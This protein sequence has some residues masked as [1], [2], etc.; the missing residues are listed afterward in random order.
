MKYYLAII[1]CLL[2]GKHLN[3][4]YWHNIDTLPRD[5]SIDFVIAYPEDAD[6]DSLSNFYRYSFNGKG[7]NTKK[8]FFKS[9]SEPMYK[10]VYFYNEDDKL[11]V[12]ERYG[13]TT[14]YGPMDSCVFDTISVVVQHTFEYNSTQIEKEI[15]KWDNG[16]EEIKYEFNNGGILLRKT[17]SESTDPSVLSFQA[18]KPG[19]SDF[20]DSVVISNRNLQ[21]VE[22]TK[23]TDAIYTANYYTNKKLSGKESLEYDYLGNLLNRQVCNFENDTVYSEE[24]VF[25]SESR[26]ISWS[27]YDTGYDGFGPHHDPGFANRFTYEYDDHGRIVKRNTHFISG[28]SFTLVYQYFFK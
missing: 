28:E 10:Q 25:D 8:Q 20:L 3:A 1:T 21:L 27:F 9:N 16:L 24:F 19:T 13:F 4:Q 22:Y 7:L 14:C 6:L 11:G 12:Y 15:I 23:Q 18:F 26:V 17:I 5:I 2:I